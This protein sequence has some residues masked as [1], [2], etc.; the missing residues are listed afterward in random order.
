MRGWDLQLQS[1]PKRHVLAAWRRCGVVAA[2]AAIAT[3]LTSQAQ[4]ADF[5]LEFKAHLRGL[6][7]LAQ[8]EMDFRGGVPPKAQIEPI[9]REA[10]NLCILANPSQDIQVIASVDDTVID[11]DLFDGYLIYHHKTKVVEHKEAIWEG[12]K[13]NS[14]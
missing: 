7:G 13:L 3:A 2:A 6:E 10:I 12:A 4:A 5:D 8:C 9:L 1:T 14:K 11:S